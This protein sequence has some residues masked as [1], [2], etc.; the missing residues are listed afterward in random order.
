MQR[1]VGRSTEHAV[2]GVADV[3][4][5]KTVMVHDDIGHRRQVLVHES[6]EFWRLK[7]LRNFAKTRE[8]GPIQRHNTVLAAEPQFFWPAGQFLDDARRN[9]VTE[10]PANVNALTCGVK[11]EEARTEDVDDG[12]RQGGKGRV[13]QVAETNARPPCNRRNSS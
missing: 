10:S 4:V 3:F 9:V 7:L 6:D 2:D 13:E 11:M 12:E 8:V 5:Y 1:I